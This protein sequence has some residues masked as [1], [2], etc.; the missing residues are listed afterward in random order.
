MLQR[1]GFGRPAMGAAF[2]R[3]LTKLPRW[4]S[5]RTAKTDRCGGRE[6]EECHTIGEFRADY[7]PVP[8]E[9]LAE[10]DPEVE[11]LLERSKVVSHKRGL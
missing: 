9:E 2:Q 5:W 10:S 6:S 8:R 3:L 4:S 11:R 7:G 1:G